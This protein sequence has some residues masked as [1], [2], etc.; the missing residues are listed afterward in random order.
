MSLSMLLEHERAREPF[1]DEHGLDLG[2][3]G[4]VEGKVGVDRSPDD[5]R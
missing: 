5:E 4:A 1:D 2:E 3:R